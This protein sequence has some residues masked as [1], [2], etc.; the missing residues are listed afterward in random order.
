MYE[1]HNMVKRFQCQDV[2]CLEIYEDLDSFKEHIGS[3]SDKLMFQCGCRQCIPHRDDV[4]VDYP[5]AMR[6]WKMRQ[7]YSQ[8]TFKCSVC[9]T[10]FPS[11]YR[12]M[13]HLEM[14]SH[15]HECEKCG[16]MVVSKR[17]LRLHMEVHREE[18]CFLCD[19]CGS[20]FKTVRDLRR[21]IASHSSERPFVCKECGKG[22]LFNNK[23]KRHVVSVHSTKKPFSCDHPGCV[24]TFA[25]RDKLRE[26]Q[27]VHKNVPPYACSFCTKAFYRKDSAKEHEIIA[28]T[29]DFPY[30]CN[31]CKKG[32]MRP[33]ILENHQ[34]TE[35]G[36]NGSGSS[37]ANL[38]K[39][40]TE[41]R[42]RMESSSNLATL[43]LMKAHSEAQQRM[44]SLNARASSL[45]Y[46]ICEQ[47]LGSVLQGAGDNDTQSLQTLQAIPFSQ[48][49]T[50]EA[51][52]NEMTYQ[53]T[54][55]TGSAATSLLQISHMT[56]PDNCQQPFPVTITQALAN[57]DADSPLQS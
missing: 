37:L 54:D 9:W 22:F 14:D 52:S 16:K 2:D 28:H 1:K 29:K 34:T 20:G 47:N 30:N 18:R 57:A 49:T 48:A 5:E 15:M 12:L 44:E 32:F 4:E 42:Q 55:I 26:H 45:S 23:L 36:K 50:T 46:V 40:R 25:R 8:M 3:H 24:R 7:Y 31:I 10:K 56:I 35:H 19:M 6:K 41:V 38:L 17:Q 51:H 33:R 13:R 27:N 21:H 39:A 53:M 43:K 11:E